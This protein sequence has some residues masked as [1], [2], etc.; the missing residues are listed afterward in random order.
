MSR[1]RADRRQV[2]GH[3]TH[4]M[5]LTKL[6]MLRIPSSK[7]FSRFFLDFNCFDWEESLLFWI[8]PGPYELGHPYLVFIV[9]T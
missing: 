3:S 6:E 7:W 5:E 4:F 8:G 2:A 1:H 9:I